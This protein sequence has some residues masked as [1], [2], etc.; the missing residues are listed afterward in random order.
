MDNRRAI[1]PKLISIIPVNMAKMR[2]FKGVEV[3]LPSTEHSLIKCAQCG[4]DGWIGPAQLLHL[5]FNGGE[6]TC[7]WCIA[8][9]LVGTEVEVRSLDKTADDKPRRT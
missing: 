6:P 1:Q 9:H 5:T 8:P 7:Y 2:V 3:P 4:N